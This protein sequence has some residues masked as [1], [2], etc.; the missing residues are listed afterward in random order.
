MSALRRPCPFCERAVA[1]NPL[2][3][4]LRYHHVPRDFEPSPPLIVPGEPCPGVGHLAAV[5]R[6][7]A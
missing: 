6:S 1:E 4:G 5:N 7:F 3:G 2:T